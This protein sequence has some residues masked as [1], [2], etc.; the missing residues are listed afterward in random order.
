MLNF[1]HDIYSNLIKEPHKEFILKCDNLN[2]DKGSTGEHILEGVSIFRQSLKHAKLQSSHKVLLLVKLNEGVLEAILA[3]MSLNITLAIPPVKLNPMRFLKFVKRERYTHAL[4]PEK[5]SFF[6]RFLLS[7]CSC[8]AIWPHRSF[9]KMEE[10]LQISPVTEKDVALVSYSSGSTG[11]P[12]RIERT[13]AVLNAQVKACEKGLPLKRGEIDFPLFPNL[14]LYNLSVGSPT[15]LP[16]IENIDL[17]KLDVQ[18]IVDQ[19]LDTPVQAM[20]GND[21]YFSKLI[22]FI[23]KEK[24][25]FEHPRIVGIGGS[26]ISEK[27]LHRIYEAF[28]DGGLF[29]IYGSTEAEP[30]SIRKYE[31]NSVSPLLGYGV[32]YPHPDLELKVEELGEI[33]LPHGMQMVGQICIRGDHVIDNLNGWLQTGDFGYLNE[34]G[35]LFLTARMGNESICKHHQH[36]SIEHQ[37]SMI[38]SIEKVAARVTKN[39]FRVFF[40]GSCTVEKVW[41]ECLIYFP[42]DIIVSVKK[43][44]KIPVDKRHLSKIIYQ[45]LS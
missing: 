24:I 31:N 20:S 17:T 14:M 42:K 40:S 32:G 25:K 30:I 26:P 8:K 27:L 38:N 41:K 39:G 2:K 19:L 11:E 4:F 12:K 22:D 23:R 16:N 9:T 3:G 1:F 21:Y 28:P 37:L 35:E 34:K 13:H 5:P 7:L 10:P 18:R 6:I 44:K 45:K 36:Y 29:S 43:V 33:K 15:L